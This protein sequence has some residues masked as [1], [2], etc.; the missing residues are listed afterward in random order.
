MPS[1]SHFDDVRVALLRTE[2]SATSCVEIADAERLDGFC[3]DCEWAVAHATRSAEGSQSCREDADDDLNDGLPSF[4]LHSVFRLRVRHS[5]FKIQEGEGR[6][7]V[8]TSSFIP[9]TSYIAQ[10]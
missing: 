9:L 6:S 8:G 7:L 3:S 5:R 10:F 2:K 4:L 1:V